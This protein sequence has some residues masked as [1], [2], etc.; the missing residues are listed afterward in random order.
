MK[1]FSCI[2]ALV[3]FAFVLPSDVD[4]QNGDKREKDKDLL[5]S[6]NW[7][8][9]APDPVPFLEP[10]ETAKT[11]KVAPGF[12]VELVAEAPM[13][14]DPV[15]AEFDMEG[16]LWVCE[17][18][19]YMKDTDG[20][21]DHDPIS[22]V[23]VLEDT[24][25][26]G[27][28]DKA[29]T[30]L[31]EVL[32]PRSLSIVEGGALVALGDGSLVFCEDTNGDLVA[33]KR[34]PMIEYAKA[35]MGNIEHAENGLH[36]AID[37][38]MYNSK[39][40]RRLKWAAGQ[41]VVDG[42]KS[43]GQW[44]MSTDAF[45]RLYHNSNSAWF[46]T[47]SEIYDRQ[48]GEPKADT[49]EVRAI[50]TN[51]AMNR[52]YKP[53]MIQED[54]RIN[55]VTSISGLAVHSHGAFGEEWEGV[56]FSFSPGTN[57][58]GAFKPDSPMPNTEKFEHLL[59][60]DEKWTKREFLASSDERFRPV[61]GS[62]G[63][64]G[65]LY[66]VD[67]NRGIIQ[68]KNFLT[69]Y[70]R[71]QSEERDLDKFIGKGRIW[72]VVP[73]KYKPKAKPESLVDGLSHP[74]LWWRLA[75][76]KRIVEE[77]KKDL[78]PVITEVAMNGPSHGRAH[79]M[80]TLAGI[81]SL[82]KE[83]IEHNLADDDW[84]VNLTALRLAG[85]TTGVSN[86]FPEEFSDA[87]EKLGKKDVEVL[88]SYAKAIT[89]KGYPDRFASVYKDKMPDW[90]KKD[91]GL[92]KTYQ[93]GLAT[94]SQFCA[95]CHQPHGK[96]MV[97]IAPS[98]VKSDW[99]TEDPD[100]LI[101]VALNGLSGPIK[102]NGETISNVPPIMPPHM[103]LSDQQLA[104]TLTYVRSAWGNK[105]DTISDDDVKKFRDANSDRF[106]PWTEA[107]LRGEGS[108]TPSPETDGE[109]ADL[110]ASGDFSLWQRVDGKPV[111]EGW[112]IEEGIVHR[113]GKGKDIVTKESYEEF[114]LTFEWKISKA[115]NS[116]VKYRTKG[117]LGLEYQVLDDEEHPDNEKPTHRA[118][119]L[120]E[121]V[122]APDDKKL[123]PVGEWNLAKIR[124]KG[125]LIEQWLNGEKVVSVEWGSDD[126][127][128]LFA[129]SKYKKHE[130][131]G[132]WAGPILLQ[133]HQDPVWFRNMKVRKL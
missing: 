50:R 126:W 101:A 21:N 100:V 128:E 76:Q 42:T 121:L 124:V 84:F 18:Q 90:V 6:T 87:A 9:W 109:G 133:D 3:A 105:A 106:A 116:G 66:I 26:D 98:L 58:V 17:F 8:K 2:S 91:K 4:A 104:D 107:E 19:S 62:F 45:G 27:K 130:G 20:S 52:A 92:A 38:W 86:L 40:G 29:T 85:E 31:D 108:P 123:K 30:F 15:F 117:S 46:F 99:V 64:D 33:D 82:K 77:N 25:G 57:T 80:W 97:N 34:T 61:N 70:L 48:Y 118:G 115:G 110:F 112:K 68:D 127:K 39:S 37:N 74:H 32:N 54:G 119:S 73:E 131:F 11:F 5:D 69:S 129:K 53:G 113:Y 16:R 89:S 125:N 55:S 12:R 75:S 35:A 65:C 22:R 56:I 67:M 49:K 14:K 71:R 41:V 79:A 43:R 88:S 132:S 13:I 96:G 95:A 36:Y 94:F 44:G 51:T 60:D 63:P 122:A 111:G 23:Q 114:E 7:R 10:E 78:L 102:V 47:D 24:D 81:Q 93:S 103:F 59:Y 120:Y 83:V 1:F 72:R 28:M